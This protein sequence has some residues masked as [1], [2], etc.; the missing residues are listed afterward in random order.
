MTTRSSLHAARE[1]AS[2][3]KLLRQRALADVA[4]ART[5]VDAGRERESQAVA[6]RDAHFSAW[7]A[8]AHPNDGLS[9][10][11]LLNFSGALAEIASECEAARKQLLQRQTEFDTYR[12][13]LEQNDRLAEL[14]DE[15]VLQAEKR[16][17]RALDERRMAELETRSAGPTED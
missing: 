11:L 9:P 17:R 5:S 14:A 4:R 13:A 16:H 15:H 1:I 12:Q 6:A 2:L 10:T 3:R 7:R 8:T